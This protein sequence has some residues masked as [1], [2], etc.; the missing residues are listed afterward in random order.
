MKSSSK[1]KILI[2]GSRS[3]IDYQ[4]CAPMIDEILRNLTNFDP[5]FSEIISGGA[6]GADTIGEQYARNNNIKLKIFPA[7]WSIGK[8][9]GFIR[10]CQ[11]ADY[12]VSDPDYIP[13]VIALWDGIS[14]G[15]EHMI[16]QASKRGCKVYTLIQK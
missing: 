9:A 1:Y 16:T 10:N 11:M 8:Q 13:I 14:K 15:T 4:R 7:D 6:K 3:I 5:V 12:I 2:C